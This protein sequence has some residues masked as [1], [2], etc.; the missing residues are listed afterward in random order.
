MWFRV[1]I[2]LW[3]GVL[4]VPSHARLGDDENI[5]NQKHGTGKP[6][7]SEGGMRVVAYRNEGLSILV[8]FRNGLSVREIYGAATADPEDPDKV[9]KVPISPELF[10]A[11]LRANS[12]GKLWLPLDR[13]GKVTEAEEPAKLK[14]ELGTYSLLLRED[15]K[16][17]A[18]IYYDQSEEKVMTLVVSDES[19]A[20]ASR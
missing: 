13:D 10:D 5:L 14:G 15:G 12:G 20:R 7:A 9:V 19:L 1:V 8:Y 2:G 18:Q 4:A 3:V 11:I 16:A 17:V 6:Q